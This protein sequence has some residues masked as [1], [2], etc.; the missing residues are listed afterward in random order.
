M[1]GLEGGGGFGS[2]SQRLRRR[3]VRQIPAATRISKAVCSAAPYGYNFQ[4]GRLVAGIE[5]DFSWSGISDTFVA[6]SATPTFCPPGFPCFT[7]LQWL[8]TDRVRLGYAF[9]RY[10]AYATGGVAYGNV[11]ATILNAGPTG[12]DS[13]IYTRVG[14]TVGGGIEAMIAP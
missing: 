1:I 4:S 2:S 6:D 12:I 14:Y 11:L 10:L 8:G 5:G 3:Q 7:S 9:D 13:E